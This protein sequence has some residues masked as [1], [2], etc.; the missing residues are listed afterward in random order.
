MY[1][2]NRRLR[3]T[4]CFHF[5]ENNNYT[6]PYQ[7]EVYYSYTCVPHEKKTTLSNAVVNNHFTH[8]QMISIQASKNKRGGKI[9][10]GDNGLPLQYN[11]LG[12]VN[13][14]PG[15]SAIGSKNRF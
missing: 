1:L 15:S 5:T 7:P 9:V 2:R 14:H 12:G 11:Y 13:G 10:F 8:A 6:N 3:A 4:K